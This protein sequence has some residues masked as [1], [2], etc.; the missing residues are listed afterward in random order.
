M[1]QIILQGLDI[2]EFRQLLHETVEEKFKVLLVQSKVQSKE[3]Y[4][5]RTEVADLFKIS[6]PTL[7]SY[8]KQGLITSFRIGYKVRYK[9]SDI[10]DALKERNYGRRAS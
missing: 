5:S 3:K 4:L 1:A 2:D 9:E 6:L 10:K 8:T 7:H